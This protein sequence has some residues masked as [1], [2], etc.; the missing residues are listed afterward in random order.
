MNPS[1]NHPKP[2][3]QLGIRDTLFRE[4]NKHEHINKFLLHSTPISLFITGDHRRYAFS[5]RS[6]LNEGA[7]A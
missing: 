2:D 5:D 7:I 4:A 3:R 6:Y 1:R